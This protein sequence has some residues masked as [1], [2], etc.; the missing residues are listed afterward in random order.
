MVIIALYYNSGYYCIMVTIGEI[1]VVH[2]NYE[3]LPYEQIATVLIYKNVGPGDHSNIAGVCH[4]LHVINFND[5][6]GA[7][8]STSS[9]C[10]W[11]TKEKID[12]DAQCTKFE[13][14]ILDCRLLRM[15][16]A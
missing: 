3:L 6:I 14:S 16:K 10:N 5:I 9:E 12:S 4:I 2:F 11:C 7:Q 13:H 15:I 1:F 8:F